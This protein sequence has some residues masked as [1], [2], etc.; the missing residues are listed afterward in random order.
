MQ[1]FEF[2]VQVEAEDITEAVSMQTMFVE[3]LGEHEHR[4]HVTIAEELLSP[5]DWGKW[6]GEE[7]EEEDHTVEADG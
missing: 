5:P 3:M 7:E 6:D 4:G 1:W 2:T